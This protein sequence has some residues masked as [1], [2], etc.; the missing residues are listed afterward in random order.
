MKILIAED[1]LTSRSVLMSVLKKWNFDVISTCDGDEA[2]NTMQNEDAPQLVVIDWEM[3]GMNGDELCKRLRGQ[4]RKRPLYLILLTSRDK[5]DDIV[6]G[7]EAG[8]DD[9]IAKPFNNAELKARVDAGRRSLNFQTEIRR[10]AE[11][12]ET[13]ARDRAVQLAHSDRMAT[14]GILSAGIAHEINNPSTFIS[15]G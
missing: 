3:P 6:H 7:F 12:M 4:E 11:E 14:L 9:Y 2:W 10:Y 1:D 13:L 15:T 5:T 8:A